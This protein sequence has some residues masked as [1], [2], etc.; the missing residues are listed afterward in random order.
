M[1]AQKS[2]MS[3]TRDGCKKCMVVGGK[4]PEVLSKKNVGNADNRIDGYKKNIMTYMLLICVRA[5]RTKKGC[6]FRVF[7]K[8]T[9]QWFVVSQKGDDGSV[10]FKS[11]F[12]HL[13]QECVGEWEI[14]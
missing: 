7:Q 11:C 9:D 5:K 6:V 14:L 13:F 1:Y 2:L 10:F 4:K 12:S 3:T 8:K